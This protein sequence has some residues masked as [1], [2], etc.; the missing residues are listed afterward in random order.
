MS[1][2]VRLCLRT[3]DFLK[4]PVASGVAESSS[5]ALYGVQV[6]AGGIGSVIPWS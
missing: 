3:S 1:E 5:V 4:P 2:R 6:A